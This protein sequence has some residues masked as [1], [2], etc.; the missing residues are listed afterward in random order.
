MD[1]DLR[2]DVAMRRRF[3]RE[4]LVSECAAAQQRHR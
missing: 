4:T 1:P 2:L 3:V